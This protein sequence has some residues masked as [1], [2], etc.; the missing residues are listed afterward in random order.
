MGV[1]PTRDVERPSPDLKSGR[2][3]GR[4]SSSTGHRHTVDKTPLRHN[5]R[6]HRRR[7]FG[8]EGTPQRSSTACALVQATSTPDPAKARKTEEAGELVKALLAA[9]KERAA[10]MRKS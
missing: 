6:R 10:V 2:P 4:R 1:E 9:K 7:Y 3:T 5:R 8:Y